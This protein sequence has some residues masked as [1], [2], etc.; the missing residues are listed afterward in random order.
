MDRW[1]DGMK[2]FIYQGSISLRV[3]Q[4][5]SRANAGQCALAMSPGTSHSVVFFRLLPGRSPSPSFCSRLVTHDHFQTV[6][7]SFLA[8]SSFHPIRANMKLHITQH[9]SSSIIIKPPIICFI[10]HQLTSINPWPWNKD[11]QFL[12]TLNPS[13]HC[14]PPF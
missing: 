6:Y 7:P 5:G 10:V 2:T 4:G 3:L 8:S 11:A 9:S 1:E 14:L 13:T 12:L